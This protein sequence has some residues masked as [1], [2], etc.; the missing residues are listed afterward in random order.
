MQP[1]WFLEGDVT[2]G[3]LVEQLASCSAMVEQQNLPAGQQPAFSEFAKNNTPV[4]LKIC[5]RLQEVCPDVFEMSP[6]SAK[7]RDDLS[8]RTYVYGRCQVGKTASTLVLGWLHWHFCGSFSL[9]AAWRFRTSV[10]AFERSIEEFN[11][12]HIGDAIP[13]DDHHDRWFDLAK[14]HLCDNRRFEIGDRLH[15][16]QILVLLSGAQNVK[17]VK[18][19]LTQLEDVTHIKERMENLSG[20]YPFVLLMDE[21]DTNTQ[22]ADRNKYRKEVELYVPDDDLHIDDDDD[23]GAEFEATLDYLLTDSFADKAYHYIGITATLHANA[24]ADAQATPPP[25]VQLIRLQ[26]PTDYYGFKLPEDRSGQEI[27]II[28]VREDS[29]IM[30]SLEPMLKDAISDLLDIPE[31]RHKDASN[32]CRRIKVGEGNADSDWWRAAIQLIVPRLS[33]VSHLESVAGL[34]SRLAV[35]H[36]RDAAP[37]RDGEFGSLVATLHGKQQNGNR[38]YFNNFA[39]PDTASLLIDMAHSVGA[40]GPRS[41]VRRCDYIKLKGNQLDAMKHIMEMF[42]ICIET[43]PGKKF[44]CAI[45]A[46]NKA[47]RAVAFKY[48][49]PGTF[50]QAPLTRWLTHSLAPCSDAGNI[51]SI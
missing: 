48:V 14:L 37:G 21:D 51:N 34:V 19:Q 29:D 5:R 2:F 32:R 17:R 47:G 27:H 4:F 9:L 33:L 1:F 50:G 46:K 36:Q 13:R 35:E 28:N 18:T 38:L 16:A 24:I 6:P 43:W 22:C 11:D 25:K 41:D 26:V 31:G 8:E 39:G 30:D 7:K 23:M 15:R 45:V 20:R 40:V 44:Y 12:K 42:K 3:G 10:D 49:P